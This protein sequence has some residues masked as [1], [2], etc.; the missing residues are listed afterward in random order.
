MAGRH[1]ECGAGSTKAV[2]AMTPQRAAFN[3]EMRELQRQLRT[4]EYINEDVLARGLR[5]KRDWKA[6]AL[7]RTFE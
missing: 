1:D 7:R 2:A 5:V 4:V 3:R 6:E